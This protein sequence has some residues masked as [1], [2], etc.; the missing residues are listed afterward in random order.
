[1]AKKNWIL[2]KRGLSQD[3][4][5][6]EKMGGAIWVYLHILDRADWETGIVYDWKDQDEADDMKLN[7]RTMRK[8]RRDL[9]EAG[10]ITC[11]QEQ[12]GQKITI[13]N[14]VNPRTYSGEV[15]NKTQG[16]TEM[17]PQKT[18]GDTQGD[19]QGSINHVTPTFNSLNQVSKKGDLVDGMIAFRESP[20]MTR[21]HRLEA[22]ENIIGQRLH[23]NPS[24]R[25]WE[26]F[27]RFV[28]DR[29]QKDGQDFGVFLDWLTAQPNFD[30]S[31]W[32]PSKMREHWPRAFVEKKLTFDELAARAGYQ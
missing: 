18:Q 8:W 22:I 12:Y 14:W 28:D 21:Q 17:S 1:M 19:T 7:I 9:D 6:R 24:G 15:L 16:D 13:H 31:Y 23:I 11:E 29:Q 30:L 10:Y 25:K 4:K 26:D 20:G 32:P 5:H 3:P 2:L 27:T